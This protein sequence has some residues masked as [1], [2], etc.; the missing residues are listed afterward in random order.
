[1][2]GRGRS[3]IPAAVAKKAK[4]EAKK[5][6]LDALVARLA[7]LGL[8]L[9]RSDPSAVPAQGGSAISLKSLARYIV[10]GEENL[11]WAVQFVKTKRRVI[12]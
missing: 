1:M 9:K 7:A 6:R 5:A 2:L 8:D 10:D 3:R 12:T 11:G 4:T